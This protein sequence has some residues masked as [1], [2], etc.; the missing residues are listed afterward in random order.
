MRIFVLL[1]FEKY[2][3]GIVYSFHDVELSDMVENAFHALALDEHRKP[4]SP[5]LWKKGPAGRTNL[6]QVWFPG[7]HTNIGGGYQN[8]EIAD[9]TLAW[10]IQQMSP[11]LEFSKRYLESI[12]QN[13][14][15]T[16]SQEWA[17]GKVEDSTQGI[18]WILSGDYRTPGDYGSR[19]SETEETIH[20]SVR[21]RMKMITTWESK[22]LK[23]WEWKEEGFWGKDGKILFEDTLGNI[24]KKLAGKDV[25]KNMLGEEMPNEAEW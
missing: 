9:I 10:M 2:R 4:F 11:F 14:A 3:L 6:K 17:A 24:E 12:I 7:V 13:H 19:P 21:I 23:G 5:T 18:M 8:Q 25:V 20:K 1:K 22:A 15:D 16:Y